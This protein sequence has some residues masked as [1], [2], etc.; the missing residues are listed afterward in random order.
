MPTTKIK[1]TVYR[2]LLP[3]CAPS[4]PFHPVVSVSGR[5][6]TGRS[7]F[8]T[9]IR[10][11][12]VL[13][14]AVLLKADGQHSLICTASESPAH[15]AYP[16][17]FFRVASITKTATAVLSMR[18]ADQQI[19]DPDRPVG[20]FFDT[21][22][23]EKALGGI[24][25]RH[26][27]SHTSGLTDPSELETSLQNNIPFTAFLQDCRVS[28]PGETFHYSNLG[29]GLIGSLM[30]AVLHQPV[31]QIF[32]D[33]LFGPLE[34]NATLEG[35]LLPPEKIM[36]VTRIL[37]YRRG[38]DLILTPLGSKPL[39]SA[40]PLYH[41][42]HTA[43]SMYTDIISL[44]KLLDVL[45]RNEPGFLSPGMLSEMCSPHASYGTVSPTLSYGYGLLR[46][47]DSSISDSIILGHQGFA[48]GCADGA[49]WEE[50]T[51]RSLIMLNGGSSEAREGRL[52]LLNRDLLR[53]AFRKE[54]PSWS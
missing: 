14:S 53:W 28:R 37:P 54:F 50:K 10:R 48:Y 35:C 31:G 33:F 4:C 52:G 19:I 51:G 41:Y 32:Q 12:H 7:D 8:D 16:D 6:L 24:T 46:I 30:E 9:L 21:D 15:T 11:H 49:F 1:N 38:H 43:G 20:L 5:N 45:I 36:P 22:D 27:L 40:D 39:L 44:Q 25:L 34:M 23:A 18:L 13:G 2:F 47:R 29:F 26:L 42:G 3:F 17:T